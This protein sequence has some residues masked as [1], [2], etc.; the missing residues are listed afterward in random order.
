MKYF[1]GRLILIVGLFLTGCQSAGVQQPQPAGDDF[2]NYERTHCQRSKCARSILS[3]NADQTCGEG[4]CS[5][6]GSV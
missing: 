1:I 4:C 2:P 6:S 3:L 5:T